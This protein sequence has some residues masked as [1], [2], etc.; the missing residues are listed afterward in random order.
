MAHLL[1]KIRRSLARER[2][3][4]LRARLAKG[5]SYVAASLAAPLR[6]RGLQYV[7]ARARV[8]Q[9]PRVE[10]GGSIVVGDDLVLNSIYAPCELATAPG[11]RLVIGDRVGINFGTLVSAA[12]EVTIGDDVS[13]GPYCIIADAEEPDASDA[14]P[15]AIGDRVWLGGRV[16]VRPGVRVG[17]GSVIT[18]GSVVS[19]TIPPGVVAG[20]NPARVVRRLVSEPAG[21]ERRVD[22][23]MDVH[24]SDVGARAA[25]AP[26][27]ARTGSTQ[28]ALRGTV[29]ADF[30]VGDLAVRLRDPSEEPVLEVVASPFG[31]VVPALLNDQAADGVDFLIVWTRPEQ[32]SLA[33][34]RAMRG[35]ATD[36]AE[37]LADVDAFCDAVLHGARR[38]RTTLVPTWAPPAD[39][40]GRGML[41]ARPGGLAWALARMNQRLME[42][43]AASSS[44]FVLDV[45]R[46]ISA[47]GRASAGAKAWYVGKIVF[48]PEVLAEAARDVKAAIRGVQGRARKLLVLDLDDTLWGGVVGDVGWENLRLGGHD[49]EGEAFVDFQHAVQQL[50]R[51][52]VV[53][54]IVSKNTE[55]VALE[56]IDSHPE[57][58]LHRRDFAGWRIDWNDKARNIADL[59]TE[60]NLG[61][62]SVV[63]ID[64][65]PVERARVREALPEVL[66]PEWPEDKLQYSRAL[67][68]LRCFDAPAVSREDAERTGHYA[69]ERER[70]ALRHEVGSVDEWLASLGTRVRAE[71]LGAANLTRAAQLLNKTNQMNLA[72]RRLAEAELGAWAAADDHELWVFSVGDRFGEA[73]ITGLLGM[74]RVGV[75][76][77]ITDFVLSCRVMGRKVEDSMA[78]VAVTRAATQGCERVVANYRPTAKNKPCLEFW[79]RSGF[80]RDPEGTRFEWSV[81]EPYAAPPA[82]RLTLGGAP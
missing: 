25:D 70:H 44:V 23:A 21:D 24:T 32:V 69:A 33:F 55:S 6:L 3:L 49:P 74:E 72:T 66:V 57:M 20:G 42:R 34:Q 77:R 65:N 46:W 52:G 82:V 18:A 62:Q 2:E 10:N 60:L 17:A 11:G 15:I 48:P 63:F 43:L 38:F 76:Q 50:T 56:A 1:A 75:E 29:L 54:G 7:G 80:R 71:P 78:H 19:M 14:A 9:R 4:P 47:G 41:D 40:C 26:G 27:K 53:V 73:G 79:E 59:T 64:D 67:A 16:T 8:M 5:R 61:L 51:R 68:A 22:G 45:Q 13:I 35:E 81:R 36:D 30:T 31:Q 28:P 12:R 39:Q 37:L 58:V